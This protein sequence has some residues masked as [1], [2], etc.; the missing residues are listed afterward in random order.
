MSTYIIN[1]SLTLTSL[2]IVQLQLPPLELT[3]RERAQL[4]AGSYSGSGLDN[5]HETERER[6]TILLNRIFWNNADYC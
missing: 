5:V 1:L 4:I 6:D 3:P 2:K